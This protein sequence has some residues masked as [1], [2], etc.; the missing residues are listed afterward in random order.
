MKF[1]TD[2]LMMKPALI[3]LHSFSEIVFGVS[4]PTGAS[5]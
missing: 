2:N 4:F 1:V 3:Y 5:V